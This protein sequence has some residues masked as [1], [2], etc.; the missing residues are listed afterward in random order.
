ML[1]ALAALA[2]LL[3]LAA[4]DVATFA[5][6]GF[7]ADSGYFMFGQYGI[8]SSTARPWAELSLVDTKKNDFVAKGQWRKV[9]PTRLE[10]GQSPEGALFSLFADAVKEARNL[11]IDHLA[12]GRLLYVLLDGAE[13]PQKLEF[14]DFKTE[15][16]WEISINKSVVD[17]KEGTK[18]SFGLIITKTA[19]DGTVRH[20][21]A[22]NPNL[23]RDGVK[24]YVINRV[25]V[26]PDEKSLVIIIEKFLSQKG[27]ESIRYMV[28]TLKLP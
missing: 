27:D 22:G 23:L 12:T 26:A 15:D 13:V 11:K 8:E 28:E 19:K 21:T 24:D 2:L 17:G 5:N 1:A 14:H 7:S 10:A 20:V 9:F 18:S 6:L 4:G 16:K 3:P 25:I